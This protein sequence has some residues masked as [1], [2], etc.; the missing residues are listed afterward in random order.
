MADDQPAMEAL[1]TFLVNILQV[2]P[3]PSDI[4]EATKLGKGYTKT[5]QGEEISSPLPPPFEPVV[6]RPLP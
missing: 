3:G 2:A 1:N 4:I 6:Q 5:I